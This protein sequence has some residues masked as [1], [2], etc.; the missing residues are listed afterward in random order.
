MAKASPEK[1]AG[2]NEKPSPPKDPG[3]EPPAHSYRSIEIVVG[4]D[5]AADG[6]V[7]R[8]SV[9]GDVEGGGAGGFQGEGDAFDGAADGVAGAGDSETVD[10]QRG[11]L[12]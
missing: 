3:T 9:E 1:G 2:T 7:G 12:G 8:A 10:G 11:V 5:E 6:G 4:A